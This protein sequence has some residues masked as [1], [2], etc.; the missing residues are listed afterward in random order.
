MQSSK[1]K[2]SDGST[3]SKKTLFLAKGK[4]GSFCFA[5]PLSKA[6]MQVVSMGYIPANTQKSTDY[7]THVF[8]EWKL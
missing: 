7:S 3:T 4:R 2:K 8:K 6:K 1:L 5:A